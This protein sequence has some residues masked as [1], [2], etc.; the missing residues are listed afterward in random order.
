MSSETAATSS[1]VRSLLP[2]LVSTPTP[3]SSC[4]AHLVE[5]LVRGQG[6]LGF[7]QRQAASLRPSRCGTTG[8]SRLWPRGTIRMS[9]APLLSS[10]GS[11]G[12]RQWPTSRLLETDI[13]DK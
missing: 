7:G 6:H 10:T 11:T 8:N 2:S 5:I 3:T 12:P 13:R 1:S 9:P 4:N